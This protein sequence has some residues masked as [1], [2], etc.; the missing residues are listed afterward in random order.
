MWRMEFIYFRELLNNGAGGNGTTKPNVPKCNY[1]RLKRTSYSR[2]ERLRLTGSPKSSCQKCLAS[3][4]TLFKITN[5]EPHYVLSK[6][7]YPPTRLHG[8]TTQNTTL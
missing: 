5:Y 2:D 1:G 3:L 4:E 7:R 6:H 8:V